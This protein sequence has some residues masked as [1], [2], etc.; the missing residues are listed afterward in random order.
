M[1]RLLICIILLT[2][3][4]LHAETFK[5]VR[6]DDGPGTGTLRWAIEQSNLTPGRDTVTIGISPIRPTAPLPSITETMTFNASAFG[7]PPVID[8]TLAGAADGLT[9]AGDR[10]DLPY[11][12]V[13][14]F[15]GNGFVFSGT[16]ST[17]SSCSAENNGGDGFVVSGVNESLLFCTAHGNANG[18]R[19]EGK[20]NEVYS[21]V[22]GVDDPPT[23]P[24]NRLDGIWLT[25]TAFENSIGRP[26]VFCG[27]TLCPPY[28]AENSA[29]GNGGAGIRV[30]GTGNTI[31]SDLITGNIGDGIVVNGTGTHVRNVYT[32]YNGGNG[33][34]L[35]Q[36]IDARDNVGTCNAGGRLI[37]ADGLAVPPA[38]R[39]TLAVD[40]LT[41]MT[42]TGDLRGEPN[43]H[44]RVEALALPADCL[45]SAG[46]G[47]IGAA[48]VT[49]DA[50]GFATF[51][52]FANK[53]GE[54]Y[55][56]TLEKVAALTL[57]SGTP[58]AS[59]SERSAVIQAVTN[60]DHRAD[61]VTTVTGPSTAPTNL[62]VTF[63][64][65]VTNNG[66]AAVYGLTVDIPKLAGAQYVSAETTSGNCFLAGFNTCALGFMAPGDTAVIRHTVNF[67]TPGS[68][69]YTAT[70]TLWSGNKDVD[71]NPANSTGRLPITVSLSQRQR[72]VRH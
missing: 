47:H 19:L 16:R 43:T 62:N 59:T 64:T 52:I 3:P 2:A 14:N 60:T 33:M 68:F 18:L 61:L 35:F 63:E 38:P 66:P 70:A 13:R 67:G 45:G 42:T 58:M 34:R 6:D 25:P 71:P 11:L 15:A 53:Y 8:G 5:V 10:V 24:G 27:V 32:S 69:Q 31:D 48:E 50:S 37:A 12:L 55:G 9:V 4:I 20:A 56:R 23:K 36:P 1:R 49:T 44:Y 17:C 29:S 41:V 46:P 21:G 72:A 22:F 26:Y 39:V 40:D 54:N 30:E 57:L 65:R 28:P 51:R 7:G